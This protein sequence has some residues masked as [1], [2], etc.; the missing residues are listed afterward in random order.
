MGGV[1]SRAAFIG[2]AILSTIGVAILSSAWAAEPKP[3]PRPKPASAAA[4]KPR[5]WDFS[6]RGFVGYDDNVALNS[7]DD[8]AED[9]DDSFSLGM[10]MAGVW[11]FY[12]DLNLTAGV[13]GSAFHKEQLDSDADD[14]SVTSVAPRL[15]AEYRGWPTDIPTRTGASYGYRRDWL[16]G[17]GFSTSH[18]FDL[19]V[20]VRPNRELE[21]GPIFSFTF[22][23]FDDDGDDP[24]RTSRD[25]VRFAAGLG[26]SYDFGRGAP[27]VAGSYQYRQAFADGDDFDTEAHGVA[28]SVSQAVKPRDLGVPWLPLVL[29]RLSG[30][31]MSRAVQRSLLRVIGEQLVESADGVS[32]TR[33]GH[34]GDVVGAHDVGGETADASENAGVFADA[35]GVLAHGDITRIVVPVFNPPVCPDGAAGG[36]GGEHGVRHVVGGFAGQVPEAGRGVAYEAAALDPDDGGD[37]GCP[38]GVVEIGARVEHLDVAC[39]VA[40]PRGVGGLMAV[41]R[42]VLV[43]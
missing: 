32:I 7:E 38:F 22:K 33:V 8:A 43:A 3:K 9:E 29:V 27:R 39:L 31:Y 20:S 41:D 34:V 12:E 18:R 25:A 10:A 37:E 14:F 6:M 40:R 35:T 36:V 13:G 30:T 5:S 26:A 1:R 19:S 42:L 28:M 4:D 17:S 11:R 23:D 24:A 21:V 2:V 16:D 15:F